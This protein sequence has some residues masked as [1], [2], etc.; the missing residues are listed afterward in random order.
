MKTAAA[1]TRMTVPEDILIRDNTIESERIW[2]GQYLIE[3]FLGNKFSELL[4]GYS[5]SASSTDTY[6]RHRWMSCTIRI[7]NIRMQVNNDILGLGPAKVFEHK[8]DMTIRSKLLHGAGMLY[9]SSMQQYIG[10]FDYL[11]RQF[12]SIR[13]IA[14]SISASYQENQYN[15]ISGNLQCNV[16]LPA[17]TGHLI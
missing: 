17:K 10:A 6:G 4:E 14:G 16:V 3:R 8:D 1:F 9:A 13:A 2:S 5:Q 11:E 12:S 15:D 7:G